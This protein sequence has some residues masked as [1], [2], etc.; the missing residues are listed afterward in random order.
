MIASKDHLRPPLLKLHFIKCKNVLTNPSPLS[1]NF[2]VPL[3]LNF[4]K[5]TVKNRILFL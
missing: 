3:F 1:P 5:S 2:T 4:K